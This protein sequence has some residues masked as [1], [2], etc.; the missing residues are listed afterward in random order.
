MDPD[1]EDRRAAKIAK[2]E[3]DKGRRRPTKVHKKHLYI[4]FDP[5]IKAF[6]GWEAV[7]ELWSL[8][9]CKKFIEWCH[10]GKA[11]PPS[12][13][14]IHRKHN[15]A[16][17]KYCMWPE[18]MERCIQVHQFLFDQPNVKSNSIILS[19]LRMVY[20]E[21]ALLKKV[22][23]MTMRSSSTTKIIIPTSPDI[24]RVWKYLDG[25][26]GRMMNHAVVSNE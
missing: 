5:D 19:I 20:A 12:R 2:N 10:I 1:H 8:A 7:V 11:F 26:L 14:E 3:Q 18:F 25:G 4:L 16:N 21:V 13:H 22:N 9:T 15:V 6:Q 24:P 17:L 23:W